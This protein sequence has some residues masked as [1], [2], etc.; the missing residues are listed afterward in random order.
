MATEQVT[1]EYLVFLNSEAILQSKSRTEKLLKYAQRADI[2]AVV[3]YFSGSVTHNADFGM[4]MP[5]IVKLME[6]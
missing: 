5:T 6:K 2:G 1:S 3:G 4:I